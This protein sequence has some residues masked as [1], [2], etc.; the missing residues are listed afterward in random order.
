MSDESL[1]LAAKIL[2]GIEAGAN[3]VA[4]LATGILTATGAVAPNNA[5]MDLVVSSVK[6]AISLAADLA[7]AG[8][9]P[10][11]HITRIKESRADF[12]SATKDLE[13]LAR[14]P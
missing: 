9:H 6:A 4:P 11:T 12:D 14:N 13:D 8:L 1:P 5:T 10:V 3:F 7:E 2:R